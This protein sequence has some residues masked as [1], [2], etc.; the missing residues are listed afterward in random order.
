VTG[1]NLSELRSA[2]AKGPLIRIVIA[3]HAGSAPRETGTSMLVGT[4]WQTGTIGGGALEYEATQKARNM[5]TKTSNAQILKVPLGPALGQCCGGTVTLVLERFTT[6][7]LPDAENEIFARAISNTTVEPLSVT[8]ALANMRSLQDRRSLVFT[9]GWLIETLQE[10]SRPFWIYGAGHIGRALVETLQ[11]LPFDITWIDTA[12][13]RFPTNIPVHVTALVAANPADVVH[14]APTNA[15]HLILTYSH[16]LDFE[17]CHQVLSRDFTSLGVIGSA[18]KRARF[19]K[20]LRALGHSDAQ[21]TRMI[22]PIGN[23]ALGKTPKA[24]A[25]G[26]VADLLLPSAVQTTRKEATL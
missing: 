21:I 18:T 5:L 12:R 26:V 2:S 13:N 22:C 19:T 8:R 17:L 16:A 24:I 4:D 1:F 6:E 25:V 14:H 11:G 9:D 3:K 7:T 15:Q 23:R 10:T 20:R